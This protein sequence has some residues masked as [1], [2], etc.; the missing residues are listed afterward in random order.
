M[1]NFLIFSVAI[2]FFFNARAQQGKIYHKIFT[3]QEGLEI[4]IIKAMTFDN[5][6]FL[7]LGGENLDIRTIIQSDKKLAIQRF[8]GVS[9]HTIPL[10]E[11]KERLIRIDQIYKR[12]D[13]KFYVQ[14][15]FSSGLRMLLFDPYTMAFTTVLVS[16]Q[17]SRLKA[18]SPVFN[19]QQDNILLTQQD[20]TIFVNR[21]NDDLSMTVMFS[22]DQTEYNFLLDS[23]TKFIPF[24]EFCVIGDDNFPLQFLSWNGKKLKEYS[25]EAFK[26]QRDIVKNKFY[27]DEIFVNRDTSFVFMNNDPELYFVDE[28]E[29]EFKIISNGSLNNNLHEIYT[30]NYSN[31]MSFSVNDE[32]L[33]FSTM[34]DTGFEEKYILEYFKS[35]SA[36]QTVSNNLKEDVWI[37]T[38]N[39]ELHYFRFPSEKIKT[40]LPDS[41]IRTIFRRDSE[42]YIVA[43]EN[44]GWFLLNSTSNEI[45]KYNLFEN[46]VPIEPRSS[47]NIIKKGNRLW[48]N[49]I[50]SIISVE[51]DASVNAYRHYPVLCLE[52]LSD[53]TLVYGTKGYNLMEFNV[54]TKQHTP[55]AVTD[56]LVIYDLAVT[57]EYVVGATDKG[58]LSYHLKS[59]E[60]KLFQDVP[61]MEDPFLLMADTYKDYPF[62][63][64]SRAGDI[65]TFDPRPIKRNLFIRMH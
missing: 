36:I 32:T 8:N 24:E 58:I 63:L 61:G 40:Y 29:Q 20:Q 1:K 51:A 3:K 39:T 30:D 52:S 65:I 7:W 42:N 45:K 64:G 18:V 19:V 53:S 46:G 9:F 26:R 48:S 16:E 62:I 34:G 56:S 59:G 12:A 5:D 25:G 28:N 38:S 11:F 49:S 15:G 13:G 41:S 43:T 10:P 21:L 4:D 22:F 54:V 23:S 35:S 6:G 47:R 2:L 27:I 44:N 50:S 55:L 60:A 14:A 37:G 31:T 17:T 57:K 33:R